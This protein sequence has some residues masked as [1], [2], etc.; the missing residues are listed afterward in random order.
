MKIAAVV[1]TCNR[2]PL[3][4]R[5]LTSI[6]KQNRKPDIVFVVSNSSDE[7]FEAENKLC[8]DFGFLPTRNLRTHT[9]TG[10]LNSSVEK[11]IKH[12]GIEDDIYFASLDD[13]D[14]WL[15]DYLQEIEN[16]NT[17][18]FDLFIGNLMRKSEVENELLVLPT[19][20]SEKDFLVGNP[21]VCGSNTFIR[22]TTLLQSGCFDE[23]LPATADRDLLVRVFQ[24]KPKY[25]ILNKH[26]VN[27]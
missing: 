9:Y 19:Q 8:N 3:L 17:D 26:L 20:L 18:N 25:K 1:I 24:Q 2:L 4:S 13:D 23:G 10:A 27:Q 5:A 11:I 14:E 15:P 6:Q 7:N 16:S 21:G 22:L 12:F